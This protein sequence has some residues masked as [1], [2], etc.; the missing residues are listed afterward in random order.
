MHRWFLYHHN[1]QEKVYTFRSVINYAAEYQKECSY[2]SEKIAAKKAIATEWLP[3]VKTLTHQCAK[4]MRKV[5]LGK[6]TED[7]TCILEETHSERWR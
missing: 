7:Q 3:R 2:K 1:Q 4:L 5:E 6:R